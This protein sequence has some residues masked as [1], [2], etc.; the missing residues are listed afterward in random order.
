MLENCKL[1]N[2]SENILVPNCEIFLLRN[3]KCRGTQISIPLRFRGTLQKL[4][5]LVC[6]KFVLSPSVSSTHDTHSHTRTHTG[7]HTTSGPSESWLSFTTLCLFVSGRCCS[8]LTVKYESFIQKHFQTYQ[9]HRL[10]STLF[11]KKISSDVS[12]LRATW[13]CTLKKGKVDKARTYGGWR[14]ALILMI[15]SC[16]HFVHKET[17]IFPLI[18]ILK[19]L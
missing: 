1:P 8:I 17:H 3:W 11:L 7:P 2:D 10:L 19:T 14:K 13:Y 6:L 15:N 4:F 5:S 18:Y 9:C 12:C 16:M